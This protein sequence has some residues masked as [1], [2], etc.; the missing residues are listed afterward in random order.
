LENRRD[1]PVWSLVLDTLH[2]PPGLRVS[3]LVRSHHADQPFRVL[4]FEYDPER[5]VRLMQH[6]FSAAEGRAMILD[7]SG[8]PLVMPQPVAEQAGSDALLRALQAWKENM[9]RDAFTFEAD[10]VRH[11]ALIKGFNLNGETLRTGVVLLED[12][13]MHWT[14]PERDLLLAGGT[15][16]TVLSVLLLW[17]YLRHRK[18]TR[19]ARQQEQRSRSQER[20][21]AKAI[22]EREVLDREVHHRVKNNLQVV[23][24][25]LNL[26]TTRLSEGQLKDEFMRSKRRIDFMA[27]V[28]HKLYGMQDLRGIDLGRFFGQ[29]V[30]SLAVMHE[31]KSRTVSTEI[32]AGGVRSDADTAIELGI[33]LCELVAN[34]YQHAFPYATGG[35]IHISLTHV[36][37]D[38]HRLVVKDNGVGM[39]QAGTA[40]TSRM[41]LEVVDALADQLDGR[42]TVNSNGGT[43]FEVLFRMGLERPS[44]GGVR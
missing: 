39:K 11:H 35:H 42:L 22:G 41:G 40:E 17:L 34:C 5:S 13:L 7:G 36:E 18:N 38:L 16:L 3:F 23:S 9:K 15:L 33:I 31:P 21:L 44:I 29:L 27:L 14:A 32:D 19:A 4:C 12:D 24:S 1:D 6:I 10:G 25:L 26:Q 30:S 2:G 8:L 28:H 20:R 43:S 37:R